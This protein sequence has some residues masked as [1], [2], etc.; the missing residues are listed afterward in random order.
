MPIRAL[1]PSLTETLTHERLPSARCDPICQENYLSDRR[2]VFLPPRAHL[3]RFV[4]MQQH[5]L[6]QKRLKTIEL[7]LEIV[8]YIVQ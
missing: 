6:K 1:R 3:C 5:Y 7:L 2:L 4:H 8:F